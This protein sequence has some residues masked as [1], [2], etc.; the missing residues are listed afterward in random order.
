MTELFSAL[1][2][3]DVNGFLQRVPLLC[4]RADGTSP[5]G[6]APLRT[7]AAS[8]PLPTGPGR[9]PWHRTPP[10]NTGTHSS[11]DA[12]RTCAPSHSPAHAPDSSRAT[13]ARDRAVLPSGPDDAAPAPW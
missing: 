5:P 12:P 4:S 1:L 13:A 9:C 8:A 7:A 3:L 11:P 10:E 6:P 2:C